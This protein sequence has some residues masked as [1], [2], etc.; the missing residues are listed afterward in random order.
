MAKKTVVNKKLKFKKS[1]SNKTL[2]PK[3]TVHKKIVIEKTKAELEFEKNKKKK[4]KKEIEKTIQMTYREKIDKF[5]KHLATLTEHND[6]P[7]VGPG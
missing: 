7:K 3:K 2:K 6:I 4:E 5:N 1:G